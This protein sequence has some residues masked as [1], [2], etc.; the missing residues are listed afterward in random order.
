MEKRRQELR[1]RMSSILT[2]CPRNYIELAKEV[3]VSSI[4]LSS[5]MQNRAKTNLKALSIIEKYIAEKEKELHG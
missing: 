4:T 1:D 2:I 3:G 5:F